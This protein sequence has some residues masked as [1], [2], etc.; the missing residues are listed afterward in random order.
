[1]AS[2][3]LAAKLLRR[4]QLIEA[5]EAEEQQQQQQQQ[6]DPPQRDVRT[7]RDSEI[8]TTESV[9]SPVSTSPFMPSLNVWNPYGEFKEFMRK[10][11][12]HYQ[13]IFKQYVQLFTNRP[14]IYAL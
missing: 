2:S 5:A 1:M 13:K 14:T 10:E 11:I 3:E 7:R 12:Q 9:S 6:Q 4:N 8:S